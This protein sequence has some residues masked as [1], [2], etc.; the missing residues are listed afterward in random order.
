MIAHRERQ[1]ARIVVGRAVKLAARV[2]LDAVLGSAEAPGAVEV[3]QRQANRIGNEMTACAGR[4]L[5]VHLQAFSCRRYVPCFVQRGK[6]D[7][8]GCI[9]HALTQE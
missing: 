9:R 6:I 4:I 3:F 1:T 2:E 8:G 5:V 7:V